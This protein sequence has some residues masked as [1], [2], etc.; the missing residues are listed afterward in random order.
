M[1]SKASRLQ[2]TKIVLNNLPSY[3]MSLSK[4]PVSIA[5]CIISL[6]RIFF[7]GGN[8]ISMKIPTIPWHDLEAPFVRGLELFL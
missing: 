3:Y 1:L 7:W 2:L 6:Q 5:Q 8:D 4:L